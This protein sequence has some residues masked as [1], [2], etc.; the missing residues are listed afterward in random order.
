M[1]FFHFESISGENDAA[2]YDQWIEFLSIY[3]NE[4][5]KILFFFRPV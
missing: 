4:L 1:P 3:L 2:T 5:L